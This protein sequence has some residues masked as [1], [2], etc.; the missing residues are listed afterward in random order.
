MLVQLSCAL[1]AQLKEGHLR[2]IIA[3]MLLAQNLLD[4]KEYVQ[5]LQIGAM[6]ALTG[7]ASAGE[8]AI[9]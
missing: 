3:L 1:S 6:A 4:S 5:T 2:E 8:P 9:L 7:D